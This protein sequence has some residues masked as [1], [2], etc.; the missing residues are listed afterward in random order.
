MKS[1][2]VAVLACLIA[3]SASSRASGA[4]GSDDPAVVAKSFYTAH[5]GFSSEN[6]DKIKTLV[7][8]RFYAA[9]AQEF[10][11]A[12]GQICA[13]EADVWTDAQDGDIGKPVDFATASNTGLKATVS[14]TYTFILDKK[15]QRKQH[16]T[17]ILQRRSPTD[18]WLV[19][20]LEGP[21]SG[22]L[23]QGIEKWFK[24]YGSAL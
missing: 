17:V 13:I 5:A 20:D 23:V 6:P 7:T 10:K 21:H 1:T 19:S 2:S 22:S 14:M 18:C 12:Q 16:A 24:E 15:H 4:C 9:L 8:P 3:L 11:C